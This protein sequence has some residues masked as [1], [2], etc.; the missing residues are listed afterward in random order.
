LRT[1]PSVL[2]PEQ[3]SRLDTVYAADGWLHVPDVEAARNDEAFLAACLEDEDEAVRSA[4][5]NMLAA[6]RMARQLRQ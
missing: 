6:A 3:K 4:A 5:S 1:D 2:S